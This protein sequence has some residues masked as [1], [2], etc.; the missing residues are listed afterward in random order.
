MNLN[1]FYN[2]YEVVVKFLIM[3]TKTIQFIQ[4]ELARRKFVFLPAAEMRLLIQTYSKFSNEDEN[5]FQEFW[6]H[7]VPQKDE[8][9]EEVY[10]YKGTL[11]SYFTI[12]VKKDFCNINRSSSHNLQNDLHGRS[13]EFIDPTTVGTESKFRIHKQWPETANNNPIILGML[14]ILFEILSLPSSIKWNAAPGTIPGS[15]IYE[16]MMSA[17]RV[18]KSNSSDIDMLKYEN[19]EPGPEG[20]HQ[21]LCELT[22]IL[23]VSRKNI[24][25]SSAGNRIWSL[26]QASGKPNEKDLGSNRLLAEMVLRDKFDTLF[27]LDREAK[28]EA[29]PLIIEEIYNHGKRENVAV[30]DV[31]T[32]EVRRSRIDMPHNKI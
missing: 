6:D 12:D 5:Q 15:S 20:V 18:T 27:L 31:L 25:K 8:S 24:T 3:P 2:K 26:D 16:P 17:F 13:I 7:A 22:V 1:R 23:L 32:F 30:R 14:R 29:L 21:D 9:E 4:S 11:V 28:H 10:P 19:G